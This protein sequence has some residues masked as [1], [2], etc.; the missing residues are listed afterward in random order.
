LRRFQTSARIVTPP[1]GERIA[2]FR[3]GARVFGL[4]NRC[5]HQGGPLGEG[6]I[7]DGCVTCP[8]HG[9]QYRPEDGVAPS[10]FTERVQTYRTRMIDGMVFVHPDPLPFKEVAP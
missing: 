4:S 10:P 1:E 2:V 6:R 7:V 8:W 3:D 9:F 5:R